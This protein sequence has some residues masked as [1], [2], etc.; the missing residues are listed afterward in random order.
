[1]VEAAGLAAV[2][3][4]LVSS[5][6]RAFAEETGQAGGVWQERWLKALGAGTPSAAGS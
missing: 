4:A 3:R 5:D 1:V 2:V 6:P